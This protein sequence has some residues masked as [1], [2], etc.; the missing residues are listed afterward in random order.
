L[1]SG[2]AKTKVLLALLGCSSGA[3][4][5]SP[6]LTTELP[7]LTAMV[8]PAADGVE[9]GITGDG[10]PRLVSQST[11]PLLIEREEVSVGVAAKDVDQV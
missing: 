10:E 8:L 4:V 7:A 2:S 3:S 1:V 5:F 6:E 11:G 9:D